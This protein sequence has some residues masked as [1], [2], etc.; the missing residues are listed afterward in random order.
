VQNGYGYG[1]CIDSGNFAAHGPSGLCEPCGEPGQ[2]DCYGAHYPFPTPFCHANADLVA[3]NDRCVSKPSPYDDGSC[4]GH[5]VPAAYCCST[6]TK[7]PPCSYPGDTCAPT[8]DHTMRCYAP[9]SATAQCGGKAPVSVGYICQSDSN[10]QYAF[11]AGMW[12]SKDAAI[13]FYQS[14]C[15]SMVSEHGYSFCNITEGTCH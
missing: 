2:P 15:D 5:S 14:Q 12:C 7:K 1:F 13:Q 3:A 9:A 6:K 8:T 11:E 4:G 10:G